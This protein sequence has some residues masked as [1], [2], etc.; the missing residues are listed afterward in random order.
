M[1]MGNWKFVCDNGNITVIR[2]SSR[3][4]AIKLYCESEGCSRE[5]VQTHCVVKPM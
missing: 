5:W 2:A 3:R 4:L 1:M